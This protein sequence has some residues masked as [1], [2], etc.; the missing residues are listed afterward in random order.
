MNYLRMDNDHR[1]TKPK[2]RS[3]TLLY[4]V[5]RNLRSRATPSVFLHVSDIKPH[6]IPCLLTPH[7]TL[8]NFYFLLTIFFFSL[9]I[10]IIT[11]HIIIQTYKVSISNYNFRALSNHR[12]RC[13]FIVAVFEWIAPLDLDVPDTFTPPQL[14]SSHS[15]A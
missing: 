13:A 12:N 6:M 8:V 1:E 11:L 15:C 10:I 9:P 2:E 4:L 14:R 7:A 3:F 5:R